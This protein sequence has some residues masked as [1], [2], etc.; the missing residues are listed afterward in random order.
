METLAVVKPSP[1]A[2]DGY[3]LPKKS[4]S[5]SRLLILNGLLLHGDRAEQA[6][7]LS[8]HGGLMS[9]LFYCS[10]SRP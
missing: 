1:A 7:L 10:F 8:R 6:I 4:G 5:E 9:Y 3:L 2:D